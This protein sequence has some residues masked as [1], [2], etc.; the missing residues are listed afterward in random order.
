[1]DK[2]LNSKTILNFCNMNKKISLLF[3]V[4]FCLFND[5]E[6]FAQLS[7]NTTTS[8][9]QLVEKVLLGYGLKASNI[10]FTGNSNLSKASFV[11]KDVVGATNLGLSKGVLL[12]TGNVLD[13]IGPNLNIATGVQGSGIQDKELDSIIKK[14]GKQTNDAVVLEFDFVPQSDSINFEY[15]FASEEYPEFNCSSF[16]DIF[17][18]FLTGPNPSGGAYQMHNL[19]IVPGS[20]GTN[21]SINSINSGNVSKKNN[22]VTCDNIDPDWRNYS[23]YF[24]VNEAFDLTS[25]QIGFD[26]FTKP[27]KARAKVICGQKYHLKIALADVGDQNYDSGVFLLGG[28]LSSNIVAA[29]T[30][31]QNFSGA[32]VSDS[33][34]VEGCSKGIVTFRIPQKL[35]TKTVINYKITGTASNVTDIKQLSNTITIPANSD[36]VQLVIDP[37]KDNI[38]EGSEMITITYNPGGCS[39]EISKSFTIYDKPLEPNLNFKY[40]SV[41][42]LNSTVT[43]PT[44]DISFSKGGLFTSNSSDVSVN[45]FSGRISMDLSKVGSYAITYTLSAANVCEVGG[46]NTVNVKINPPKTPVTGFKFSKFICGSTDEKSLEPILVSNFSQGGTFSTNKELKIDSN[47]GKLDITGIKS[48]NYSVYYEVKEVSC[49]LGKK[50]STQ[51]T[52]LSTGQPLPSFSFPSPICL[53]SSTKKYTPTKENG[54]VSGGTFEFVSGVDNSL[55]INK[56]NGAI[57]ISNCKAGVYSMIYRIRSTVDCGRRSPSVDIILIDNTPKNIEFTY[58]TLLCIGGANKFPVLSNGFAKGGRF[59]S[60]STALKINE[61][62]GEIDLSSGVKGK[63]IVTYT[64][65]KT[66]CGSEISKSV[67]FSLGQLT[68]QFSDFSYTTPVCKTLGTIS[69]TKSPNFVPGGVFSSPT[70]LVVSSSTGKIFLSSSQPGEFEISYKLSAIGCMMENTSKAKIIIETPTPNS[71]FSYKR[72]IC[73]NDKN[74]LPNLPVDFTKGGRFFTLNSII[75]VDSLTGLLDLKNVQPDET[76]PIK[77]SITSKVCGTSTSG[78][79]EVL[80]SGLRTPN[81]SFSYSIS[82]VC[83]ETADVLPKLDPRFET[84]GVFSSSTGLDV[85]LATGKITVINSPIGKHSVKYVLLEK[86]CISQN[87][88]IVEFTIAPKPSAAILAPSKICLGDTVKLIADTTATSV[89]WSGP[90]NFKSTSAKALLENVKLNQSGEYIVNLKTGDCT[91]S[92]KITI[93]VDQFEKIQIQPIGPFCSYDSFKY[94]VSSNTKGVWANLTGLEQHPSDS[95]KS[96]FNPSKASVGVSKIKLISNVGCGGEGQIEVVVNPLPTT[97]FSISDNFGCKPFKFSLSNPPSQQSDSLLFEINSDKIKVI[98][99]SQISHVINDSGCYS[100]KITNFSKGC[101]SSQVKENV[102]CIDERPV[103]DFD[104]NK[105]ELDVVDPVV[106]LTNKSLKASKYKWFL[107]DGFISLENNPTYR[108]KEEAGMYKIVLVAYRGSSCMDT[109]VK[110]IN[111]PDKFSIYVPNT[112]TPNQDKTNEVFYPVISKAIVS[113]SYDFKIYDRWGELVFESHDRTKGWNGFYGNKLAP[114]GTYIWKISV[115]DDVS[116]ARKEFIGHVNLLK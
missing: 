54:F 27:L 58:D 87:S 40:D 109:L 35:N 103:A 104:L 33:N 97:D 94:T 21:V 80:I 114:D 9:T 110:E 81:V 28:S 108:Y 10:T 52:L 60:S 47:S 36:S 75:K 84:G 7:I 90:N 78:T 111:I 8:P 32:I 92:G 55:I 18:F 46:T 2:E 68:P 99:S 13:A 61:T 31:Q 74:A 96:F 3:I 43:F 23:K 82:K 42:C 88:K 95:S 70:N 113:D 79:T 50:D 93:S 24:I 116:K 83:S 76:Y 51:I 17:G 19:A 62:T 98:G 6:I 77:Y 48:G 106:I 67:S 49:L 22:P 101:F 85:D 91:N 16:N 56:T 12:S 45:K 89:V 63:H 105:S 44:K 1:M 57:D 34:L 115:I 100:M 26:G 66:E 86:L 73:I 65:P 53:L 72:P 25:S 29:E 112:F 39:G 15:V 37:I 102:F 59:S 4:F 38:D 5:K 107:G 41:L 20:N 69:P 14:T 11:Y 71:N 64:Y 30:K